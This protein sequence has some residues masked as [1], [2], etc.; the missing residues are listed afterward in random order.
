MATPVITLLSDWGHTDHYVAAVK[1][2]ILR[3]L[4]EAHIIDISHEVEHF[5]L[6]HASFIFSQAFQHFPEG[7]A[8]IL[9]IDTVESLKQ[10]HIVVE[11]FGQYFIGADNG[12]IPLVLGREPDKIIIL[13]IPQDTGYFTFPTRDR[14]V[15][16]AC[17]LV[18]GKPIEE[19]GET[20]N[21]IK[22]LR[23]M[24]A[25][26]EKDI[27]K[28]LVMYVDGFENAITNITEKEFR[29]VVGNKPFTINFK[30]P[31]YKIHKIVQAYGDVNVIEMCALFSTSGYLQIAVNRGKAATLL[32]LT[33]DTPVYV[34]VDQGK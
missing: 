6:K 19:L 21:S 26:I 10:S 16:A 31:D 13:Q 23:H 7:T 34:Y 30:R 28:G 32:G 33:P 24:N 1:G 11:A 5:N 8:H 17:H 25:N 14:F 27:I 22:V 9:A 29:E 15:R 3:L 2:A 12:L 20:T 18:Q 4:P